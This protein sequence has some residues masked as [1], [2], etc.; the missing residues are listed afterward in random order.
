MKVIYVANGKQT[1]LEISEETNLVLSNKNI[2]SISFENT[3][4]SRLQRLD[5]SNNQLTS[6]D[7]QNWPQSLQWLD[8]SDN[9]LIYIF[10]DL[11]GIYLFSL[12]Q[13]VLCSQ[14]PFKV[15]MALIYLFA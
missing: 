12:S 14:I 4:D 7:G 3:E 2:S 1:I 15:S 13:P 6:I 9:P 5:L 10:P 11:N 8:L